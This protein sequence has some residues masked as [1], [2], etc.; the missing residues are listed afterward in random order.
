MSQSLCQVGGRPDGG[1]AGRLSGLSGRLQA[2]AA[3]AA[4]AVAAAVAAATP[5]PSLFRSVNY[6]QINNNNPND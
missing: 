1:A 2:A 3:A 6:N 5:A 4:A